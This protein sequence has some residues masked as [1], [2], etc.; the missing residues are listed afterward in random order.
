MIYVTLDDIFYANVDFNNG[1]GWIRTTVGA[2][3][4]VYSPSPL[5]ARAPTR[6]VMQCTD[7]FPDF[8]R[9]PFFYIKI[10]DFP[11]RIAVN[12]KKIAHIPWAILKYS[13]N[14]VY[15]TIFRFSVF[16]PLDNP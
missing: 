8:N 14:I 1:P 15:F 3:Q 13:T 16:R 9:N 5:A 4:W 11:A 10:A 2:S 7:L 6:K 12:D